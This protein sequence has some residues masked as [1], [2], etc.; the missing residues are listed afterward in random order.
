VHSIVDGFAELMKDG[1]IKLK[2]L[3]ADGGAAANTLLLQIQSNLLQTKIQRAKDLESTAR[4]AASMAAM[5]LGLIKKADL[6]KKNPV[7]LD[8]SPKITAKQVKV[9]KDYW[10]LCKKLAAVHAKKLSKNY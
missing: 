10:Q 2:V 3:K 6:A 8:V 5:S 9:Q 1:G 4:G 7:V